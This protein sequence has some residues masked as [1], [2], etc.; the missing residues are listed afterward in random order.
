MEFETTPAGTR[1]LILVTGATGHVG[2]ELVRQLAA[3]GHPVR[4][5]T[6]RPAQYPT[7]AGVQVVAGDCDDEPGL[8]AAFAG[9]DHAFLMSAQATGSV[10]APTHVPRLVA[11]ARRAGVRR[12]VLLSVY[13]GGRGTDPVA[14]WHAATEA[15][16]TGSGIP[17]TLLRPGRFMSNALAWAHHLRRGDTVPIPFPH[18]PAAAIDPADIAAVALAELTTADHADRAIQ[19]SGPQVLT[20]TEELAVLADLLGRPLTVV[21]P[22]T[23]D[24]RAGMLRSGMP[25]DVVDAVIH[26]TLH[27]TDGA[28]VLP[29]VADLLGRPAT[30]FR[31]WARNHLSAY[32]GGAAA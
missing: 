25:P 21:E 32:T 17:H 30:P 19:L 6:R 9:V 5:M 3:A 26:R 1:P 18:R 22:S 4:A 27:T 13:N 11:A 20:P 7:P 14:R 31:T 29:A 8:A 10:P 28:E 2:A 23:S 12:L 16:V 24:A 15:A